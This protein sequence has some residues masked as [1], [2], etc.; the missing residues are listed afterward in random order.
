MAREG[1]VPGRPAGGTRALPAAPPRPGSG[2]QGAGVGQHGG[3]L[4]ERQRQEHQQRRHR[5]GDGPGAHERSDRQGHRGDAG[6]RGGQRQRPGRAE[7]RG[8]PDDSVPEP[9]AGGHDRAHPPASRLPHGQLRGRLDGVHDRLG[10]GGPVPDHPPLHPRGAAGGDRARQPAAGCGRRHDERGDRLD[11]PGDRRGD[12]RDDGEATD[13]QPD[14]ELAVQHAVDVIDDRGQH[15][16]ATT[17]QRT[18]GERHD[19][20]VHLHPAAPEQVQGDVVGTQPLDVPQQRA[21]Q[22]ERADRDDGD[23]QRQH[24]GLVRRLDD[25]PP[26]GGGECDTGRGGQPTEQRGN[27]SPPSRCGAGGWRQGADRERGRRGHRRD[28]SRDGSVG[29]VQ[30]DL[31][32]GEVEEGAAMGDDHHAAGRVRGPAR[33]RR[34]PAR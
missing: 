29:S 13:G 23:Q 11:E 22:A 4:T 9:V 12:K 3:G 1:R 27:P 30:R 19:G 15:V 28:G 10:Q 34:S 21:S 7:P 32:V 31:H 26:G 2:G 24:R 25:Q 18:R 8:G 20:V 17:A 6:P 16:A 5:S 33:C 14:P